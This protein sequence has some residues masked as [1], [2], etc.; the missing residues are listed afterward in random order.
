MSMLY[1][2]HVKLIYVTTGRLPFF[3]NVF[4]IFKVGIAQ[5]TFDL[6]LKQ[7]DKHCLK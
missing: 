2:Q 5:I 3:L 7:T 6:V 1:L 4:D